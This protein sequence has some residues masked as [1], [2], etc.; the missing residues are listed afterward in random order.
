MVKKRLHEL[1]IPVAP[2]WINTHWTDPS[3]AYLLVYH[4][5]H[6]MDV[7]LRFNNASGPL[8]EMHSSSLSRM[9]HG[10]DSATQ[11][12]YKYDFGYHNTSGV[13][14]FTINRQGLECQM[15]INRIQ[16]S[17]NPNFSELELSKVGLTYI[18]LQATNH[19]NI[20]ILQSLKL[21]Q[22]SS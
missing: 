19:V 14:T 22:P 1:I 12:T 10:I 4:G 6:C 3:S 9:L 18:H 2:A 21:T 8:P 17:Y 16:H 5:T 20:T 13:Q 7:Y 15:S 11:L